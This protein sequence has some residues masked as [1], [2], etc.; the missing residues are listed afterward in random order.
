MNHPFKK[1]IKVQMMSSALLVFCLSIFLSLG[2]TL[3]QNNSLK[4]SAPNPQSGFRTGKVLTSAH[5]DPDFDLNQFLTDVEIARREVIEG[6]FSKEEETSRLKIL[7]VAKTR[8]ASTLTIED[9]FI[10]SH[11]ILF[12]G[13]NEVYPSVDFASIRDEYIDRFQQ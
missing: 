13:I 8:S 12:K 6:N 4:S 5:G 7:E 9:T 10:Q 11:N 1:T 2:E 3:A